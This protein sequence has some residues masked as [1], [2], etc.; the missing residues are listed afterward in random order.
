MLQAFPLCMAKQ[1]VWP[2]FQVSSGIMPSLVLLL[3]PTGLKEKNLYFV[4]TIWAFLALLFAKNSL[5]KKPES[6]S[7]L[8]FLKPV[9]KM[10]FK[11]IVIATPAS[12]SFESWFWIFQFWA[13]AILDIKSECSSHP[14]LGEW[15]RY[16][17]NVKL[18]LGALD[19]HLIPVTYDKYKLIK[20]VRRPNMLHFCAHEK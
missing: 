11:N 16:W 19:L 18:Y 4:L 10:D 1:A 12:H 14:Y 2:I 20:N 3:T 17:I 7:R 8:V 9:C 5:K 6:L 13:L 15:V